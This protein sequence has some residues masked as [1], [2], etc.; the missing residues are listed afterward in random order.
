MF[1]SLVDVHGITS[2][3]ACFI[4]IDQLFIITNYSL[5]PQGCEETSFWMLPLVVYE[6]L[7][8]MWCH[9]YSASIRHRFIVTEWSSSQDTVVKQSIAL[10]IPL[11][12]MN[13]FEY[14]LFVSRTIRQ[15][16]ILGKPNADEIL[17]QQGAT[18]H[19]R[20]GF[21]K[22]LQNCLVMSKCMEYQSTRK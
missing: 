13:T 4:S 6:W 19:V 11:Q 5:R 10:T 9:Y 1:K 12:V 21:N 2:G 16:T 3:V 22:N 8:Q 18:F 14:N 15:V 7:I 17:N 20:C